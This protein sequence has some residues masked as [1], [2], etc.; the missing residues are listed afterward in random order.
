MTQEKLDRINELAHFAKE[1]ELT[2]D[3]QEERAALRKEY[4]E[5]WRHDRAA[6][7]HLY[8][9]ARRKEAQAAEKGRDAQGVKGKNKTRCDNICHAGFCSG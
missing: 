2:A 9:H 1:R 6:G 7:E 3:E 8:R 4:I 5:D